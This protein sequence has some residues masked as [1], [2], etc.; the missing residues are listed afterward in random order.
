VYMPK[1]KAKTVVS[2]LKQRAVFQP[3]KIK[4]WREKRKL[5]QD[6]LAAQVGAYLEE[7]GLAKGYSYA[8]IGRLERG[9]IGYK[10]P[11]MEAIADVLRTD[12]ASLI[13]KDPNESESLAELLARAPPE[14][15]EIVA[16]MLSGAVNKTG[17]GN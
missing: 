6:Q 12:V 15:R 11:V 3:T 16:D 10:Q 2:R 8:T 7:R 17:T 13:I 1:K 4:L 9:L 14:R 5:T